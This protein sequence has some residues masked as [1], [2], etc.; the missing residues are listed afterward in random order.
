MHLFLGQSERLFVQFGL[1]HHFTKLGSGEYYP[2][3]PG[4]Y[5]VCAQY[6]HKINKNKTGKNCHHLYLFSSF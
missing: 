6:S 4:M 1:V 2:D 5:T 3:D